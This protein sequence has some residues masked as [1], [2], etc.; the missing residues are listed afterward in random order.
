MDWIV[1]MAGGGGTRLWPL[2]R[3]RRPKQFLGLLPGGESLLAAT[4]ARTLS[5]CPIERTVVVTAASQVDEVLAA[6]PGLLAEQRED[7]DLRARLALRLEADARVEFAGF[8]DRAVERGDARPGLRGDVL[9]DAFVGAALFRV[10]AGPD[11]LDVA[12]YADELADLL[13]HAT[14]PDRTDQPD[15]I[16]RTPT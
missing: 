7:P 14:R 5:R 3:R 6:V 13:F 4:V 8:V 1:I 9:F 10:A 11:E 15:P 2:S 16:E 12:A